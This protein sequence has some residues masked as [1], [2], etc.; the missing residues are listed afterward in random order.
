MLVHKMLSGAWT[1]P[2]VSK[3]NT[4]SLQTSLWWF[5]CYLVFLKDVI[6]CLQFPKSMF[7]VLNTQPRLLRVNETLSRPGFLSVF[8]NKQSL[9][10]S[11]L[12]YKPTGSTWWFYF[13][14]EESFISVW[15]D[16]DVHTV[17]QRGQIS[18]GF[19]AADFI[20]ILSAFSE[21]K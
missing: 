12:E 21:R 4:E 13:T 9:C 2:S 11:V 20:S 16:S 10:V 8:N 3:T 17:R 14:V 7:S 5:V 15:S 1:W 18:F 19:T 6:Q